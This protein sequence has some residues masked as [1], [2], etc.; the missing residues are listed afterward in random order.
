MVRRSCGMR[1][2]T[3][4]RHRVEWSHTYTGDRDDL[5]LVTLGHE[6]KTEET[7]RRGNEVLNH[8][9]NGL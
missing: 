1:E 3:D 4:R 5:N 9:T 7:N 2:H 6:M 8:K